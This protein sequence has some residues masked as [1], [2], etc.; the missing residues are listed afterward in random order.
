MVILDSERN[1]MQGHEMKREESLGAHEHAH[2][3]SR[4]KLGVS[5]LGAGYALIAM[6][7]SKIISFSD[8]PLLLIA[9][10]IQFWAGFEFYSIDRKSVV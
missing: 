4:L 7:F 1:N 5:L 9:T 3:G 2:K 8:I 6:F 10:V